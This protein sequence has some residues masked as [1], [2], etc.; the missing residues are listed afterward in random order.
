MGEIT[1]MFVQDTNLISQTLTSSSIVT[2]TVTLTEEITD[3][4]VQDTNLIFQTF[5]SSSIVTYTVTLMGEI[6][7]MFC[8]RYQFNFSN[9]DQFKYRYLYCDTNGR[10]N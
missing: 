1:D 9:I 8:A 6:T 5:T 3:M 4:F 2:Y 10:D 7:D